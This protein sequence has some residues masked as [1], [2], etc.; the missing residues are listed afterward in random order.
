MPIYWNFPADLPGLWTFERKVTKIKYHFYYIISLH[1]NM[2]SFY[3]VWKENTLSTWFMIVDVDLD[4]MTK[5]VLGFYTV[6]LPFLSP[7]SYCT[8]FLKK[9]FYM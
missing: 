2:F 1:I 4:H 7:F 6:K 3:M 8:L 5:I 9:R